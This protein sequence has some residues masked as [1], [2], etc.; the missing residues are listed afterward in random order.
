[1]KVKYTKRKARKKI[2]KVYSE[3]ATWLY[4]KIYILNMTPRGGGLTS[5]LPYR[6]G[7]LLAPSWPPWNGPPGPPRRRAHWRAA[8]LL[9]H[10]RARPPPSRPARAP[11]SNPLEW[12]TGLE[13]GAVHQGQPPG[14]RGSP[15]GPP[16]GPPVRT[17][18][19]APSYSGPPFRRKLVCVQS[20]GCPLER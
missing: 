1:M 2:G 12:P 16:D 9:G 3:R 4:Q 5:R 11:L 10:V 15:T 17:R 13:S 8:P 19:R 14:L 6:T 20:S 7:P 18:N